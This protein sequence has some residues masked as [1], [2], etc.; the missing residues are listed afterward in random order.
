[1]TYRGHVKQ[2]IIVLE[3]PVQL[4]EGAEVE[5]R[6]SEEVSEHTTCPEVETQDDKV[7]VSAS[8]ASITTVLPPE[9]F[10]DWEK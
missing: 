7:I 6:A 2:G 4:P 9:D 3:P 8:I 5:V 10:S 1:M